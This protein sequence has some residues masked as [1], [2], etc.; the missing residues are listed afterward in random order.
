MPDLNPQNG[1]KELVQ[2]TY[3][4]PC[5]RPA[6]HCASPWLDDR[7][8][9]RLQGKKQTA[10][11]AEFHAD[12]ETWSIFPLKVSIAAGLLRIYIYLS[13]NFAMKQVE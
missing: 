6:Q 12:K 2:A 7:H 5:L 11:A 1:A 10:S 13:E 3:G 8:K 4:K 9:R